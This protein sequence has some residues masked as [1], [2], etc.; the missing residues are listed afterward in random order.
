MPGA[1]YNTYSLEDLKN[2]SHMMGGKT[3]TTCVTTKEPMCEKKCDPCD[4]PVV[5]DD[6]NRGYGY[7]W[8]YFWVWL[9]IIWIIVAIILFLFQPDF[10]NGDF[11]DCEEECR[12]RGHHEKYHKGK[13]CLN[14]GNLLLWSLGIAIVI[15]VLI[16]IF[17]AGRGGYGYGHGRY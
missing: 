5:V 11:K 8:G 14:F 1:N 6:C 13:K 2:H 3:T 4:K 15:V 9:I 10:L 16:W 17:R 7:G 12:S